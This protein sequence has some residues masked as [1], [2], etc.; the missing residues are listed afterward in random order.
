[1]GIDLNRDKLKP[2]LI[3]SWVPKASDLELMDYFCFEAERSGAEVCIIDPLYQVLEDAQSSYILNGQ[4]LATLCNRIM[5][6]GAT[7][8]LVDHA[9]RSSV[10]TKD[11][12]PLE[13]D[14]ISGAGKAEYFRQWTL[15]SRRSKFIANPG[16]PH[17]H[18]LW[19]TIG[20]SAGHAS[21][22]TLD[23]TE[24]I[25]SDR[26]REYT[27]NTQ[28]RSEELQA[29]QEARKDASK[30]KA[31]QKAEVLEARMQRKATELIEKV[32][33]GDR[34]LALTQTDIEGR[35]GVSGE[36]IKRVLGIVLGDRRLGKVA[37][38]VLKNGHKYDGYMLSDSFGIGQERTV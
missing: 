28:S 8:I 16:E 31:E 22:W 12:Q 9:K 6:M 38:V 25:H 34:S 35:I 29:R 37:K 7:P 19:L 10:N 36:E 23:I 18:D 33:K 26:S 14:D 13:L 2:L 1:M 30:S 5:A 27:V 15:V 11:F 24:Q 21:T 3:S 20:G 32:Y 17:K 4:Q